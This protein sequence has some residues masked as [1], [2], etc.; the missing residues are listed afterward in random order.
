MARVGSMAVEASNGPDYHGEDHRRGDLPRKTSRQW[1]DAHE[2]KAAT[3]AATRPGTRANGWAPAQTRYTTRPKKEDSS[4]CVSS[5]APAS[6]RSEGELHG[7]G[8]RARDPGVQFAAG[9]S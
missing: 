6:G 3:S 9:S 5:A 7:R 2:A 8:A 1:S 4:V